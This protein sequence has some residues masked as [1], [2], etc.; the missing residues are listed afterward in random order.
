MCRKNYVLKTVLFLFLLYSAAW[1][2]PGGPVPLPA[3]IAGTLVVATTQI[4]KTKKTG[5]GPASIPIVTSTQIT[6]DD[7]GYIVVV[8][9]EDG[10]EYKPVAEDRDGFNE[11]NHY[12]LYIPI[13]EKESQPE[14]ANPG[15]IA[16]IHVYKDGVELDVISPPRGQIV[17]GPHGSVAEINIAVVKENGIDTEMLYT[18]DQLDYIVDQRVS[19]AV[20]K[21]D[22]SSDGKIGLEEAI[23]A[24]RVISGLRIS[25]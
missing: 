9:A 2:G 16:I 1:A 12:I 19:L 24:L 6:K 25:R 18:Q 22:I 17:V 13:Y 11:D 14:G 20:K 21:W 8:T 5:V 7:H 15:D 3:G 10:S 4:V 23:H